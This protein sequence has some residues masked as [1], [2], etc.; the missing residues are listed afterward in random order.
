M[1]TN[2][3]YNNTEKIMRK[4]KWQN[5]YPGQYDHMGIYINDGQQPYITID[6]EDIEEAIRVFVNT[7]DRNNEERDDLPC[8]ATDLAT[9]KT[10]DFTV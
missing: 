5:R 7:Y 10:M 1:A 4:M 9:G 3:H 6:T 2:H 8:V